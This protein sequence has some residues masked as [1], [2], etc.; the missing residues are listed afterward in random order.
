MTYFCK[1]KD[2]FFS[3]YI[4]FLAK[5][6][7]SSIFPMSPSLHIQMAEWLVM[8]LL[9]APRI[10]SKTFLGSLPA[11]PHK[12][13]FW[14]HMPCNS[15]KLPPFSI[16]PSCTNGV[17]FS[18]EEVQ[19]RAVNLTVI[20]AGEETFRHIHGADKYKAAHLLQTPLDQ[21]PQNKTEQ[22]SVAA[23][24]KLCGCCFSP[25]L[26]NNL[27]PM[28]FLFLFFFWGFSECG[29]PQKFPG[30]RIV[31]FGEECCRNSVFECK[32]PCPPMACCRRIDRRTS[33]ET[34]ESC[35]LNE[36]SPCV[37]LSDK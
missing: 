28:G 16:L 33:C 22:C 27:R 9:S 31:T 7:N 4:H 2:T 12:G 3:I 32:R 34:T 10:A 21:S 15:L 6:C 26:D 5:N 35:E 29:R 8:A 24:K 17:H 23:S 37:S 11:L 18:P 30:L 36:W 20:E 25:K 19:K 14:V 1:K 13:C